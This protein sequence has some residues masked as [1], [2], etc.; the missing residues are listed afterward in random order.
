MGQVRRRNLVLRVHSGQD[1]C[2]FVLSAVNEWNLDITVNEKGHASS[3]T[4]SMAEHP[5]QI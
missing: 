5:R 3:P 2:Q 4:Q 1:Q